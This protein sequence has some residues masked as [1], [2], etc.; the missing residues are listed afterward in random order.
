M[1]WEN[2]I[3]NEYNDRE[4][5]R[6]MLLDMKKLAATMADYTIGS[7]LKRMYKDDPEFK[8]LPRIKHIIYDDLVELYLEKMDEMIENMFGDTN[9]HIQEVVNKNKNK[10]ESLDTSLDDS[11]EY[12]S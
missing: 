7:E 1:S 6:Q 12:F 10:I 5:A 8:N 9:A 3:K 11:Y 2:I 4:N